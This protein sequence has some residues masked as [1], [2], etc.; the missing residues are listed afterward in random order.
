M[1]TTNLN[2]RCTQQEMDRFSATCE[3]ANAVKS[4]VLRMLMALA[5]KRGLIY[6]PHTGA[7]N[8]RTTPRK[9]SSC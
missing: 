1:L 5:V 8:L 2:V 4:E 3:E 7:I 9:P 6:N